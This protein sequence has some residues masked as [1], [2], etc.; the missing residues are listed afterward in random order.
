MLNWKTLVL[1]LSLACGAA[2]P[3]GAALA[4]GHGDGTFDRFDQDRSDEALAELGVYLESLEDDELEAILACFDKLIEGLGDL[5]PGST[6]REFHGLYRGLA[7]SIVKDIGRNDARG[8]FANDLMQPV[9]FAAIID[10]SNEWLGAVRD[11]SLYFG[12]SEE[13]LDALSDSEAWGALLGAVVTA[14]TAAVVIATAPVTVPVTTAIATV[15]A[16][17]VAGV[18]VG[19]AVGAILEGDDEEV[20]SEKEADTEGGEDSQGAE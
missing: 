3:G 2:A 19:T 5:A 16:A 20:S 12:Q 4:N 14:G 13:D 9:F 8:L 11:T 17:V 1:G 6:L 10:D 15:A 7:R 18:A